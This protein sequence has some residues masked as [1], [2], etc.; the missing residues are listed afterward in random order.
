MI[1]TAATGI[2]SNGADIFFVVAMTLLSL[3][4]CAATIWCLVRFSSRSN[5][6]VKHPKHI[7]SLIIF[8]GFIL[9]LVLSLTVLGN[10]NE[11]DNLISVIDL[12][13]IGM[14]ET[15]FG[16]YPVQFIL[17]LA[18]GGLAK[19]FNLS[20]NAI[21][22]GFITKLPMILCDI[23]T[24]IVL[25][26]LAA[27]YKNKSL[28]LIVAAIF[29]LSPVFILT[30]G[31]YNS[32]AS[33]LILGMATT[34]YFL[35]ERNFWGMFLSYGVTSVSSPYGVYMLPII[36]VYGVYTFIMAIISIRREV[37]AGG[38]KG[39]YTSKQTAALIQV[40]LYTICSFIAAYLLSL[41][42][43]AATTANPFTI[44]NSLFIKPIT[45][46]SLFCGN[47]LNIFSLFNRNGSYI[48]SNFSAGVFMAVFAVIAFII[49]IAVFLFKRNRT[50]MAMLTSYIFM[51]FCIYYIGFRE[52][53]LA[54]ALVPMLISY[55][56]TYDKR[57]ISVML[58]LS[59][60]L[61]LNYSLA[62]L[63]GGYAN[64]IP[65]SVFTS[66]ASYTGNEF[67][68]GGLKVF[69]II[70]SALTVIVHILFTALL[71]DIT[72]MGRRNIIT[73]N[74]RANFPKAIKEFCKRTAS[75]DTQEKSSRVE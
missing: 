26:N 47:A 25:Y 30:A 5:D 69:S 39:I 8:G 75:I 57:L 1:F 31:T 51:T 38:F 65:S 7:L 61:T 19:L 55:C 11:F 24:A 62:M 58:A 34:L 49:V 4:A 52:L 74:E 71:L 22:M 68:T 28:G 35:L 29:S 64:A 15:S 73:C 18:F 43:F 14:N 36:A 3:V 16:M 56:V 60:L 44:M 63:S 40:P 27:K 32:S 50:T 23:A 6:A 41:F 45:T 2:T 72:V 67:F 59:V 13:V 42:Q 46:V 12:G 9:R 54:I 70:L 10:R 20:G 48:N 21:G 53:T 66:D 37:P 17:Y 33:L